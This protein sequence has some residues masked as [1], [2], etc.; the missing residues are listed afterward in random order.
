MA[1]QLFTCL[2]SCGKALGIEG[3]DKIN[4]PCLSKSITG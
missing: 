1:I 4:K 3:E 2:I